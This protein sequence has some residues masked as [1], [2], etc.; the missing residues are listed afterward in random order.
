MKT[1]LFA[2]VAVAL[3]SPAVAGSPKQQNAAKKPHMICKRDER[4]T[5]THMSALVCK[6]AEEW[7]AYNQGG[8]GKLNTMSHNQPGGSGQSTVPS[9]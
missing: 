6:T 4:A 5:G 3:A 9:G 2:I 7:D 1:I 8:A